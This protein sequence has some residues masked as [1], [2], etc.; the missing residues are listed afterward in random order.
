M[1]IKSFIAESASK[2]LKKVRQEMGGDAIVLKTRN[3]T[4]DFGRNSIEVTACLEKATVAQTS[5][6]LKQEKINIKEI[7][8]EIAQENKTIFSTEQTKSVSPESD[9]VTSE[10]SFSDN[11]KIEVKLDKILSMLSKDK[12]ANMLGD[13][14][15]SFTASLIESDFSNQ[16]I[17]SFVSRF[18]QKHSD[19]DNFEESTKDQAQTVLVEMFAEIME[20][21]FTIKKS[22]KVMFVGPPASGKSSVMS[23][24]AA[25]LISNKNEEVKLLSVDDVK[26]GAHDELHNCADFLGLDTLDMATIE[27]TD[28]E[29]NDAIYLIDTPSLLKTDSSLEKLQN[30]VATIK[31]DYL[32]AVFPATMRSSDIISMQES[33]A[34]LNITHTV[35]TMQDMTTA[36]GA[37]VTACNM[38]ES[39]LAF[40]SNKPGGSGLLTTPDPNLLASGIFNFGDNNE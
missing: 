25:D 7:V 10:K 15:D 21:S 27:T 19:A 14:L 5:G 2:A 13:T 26:I 35:V 18:V 40:F 33:F 39:K 16:F 17:E 32:I 6:I 30:L 4:D 3:V 23:K 24:I 22:S 37:F 36:M 38:T 29:S 11:K 1:I 28:Q 31:P 34:T 9:I 20:P 8:N 12:I